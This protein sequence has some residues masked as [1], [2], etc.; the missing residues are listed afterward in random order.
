ME[1]YKKRKSFLIGTI[2]IACI[3]TCLILWNAVS[4]IAGWPEN[5]RE[6]F[7]DPNSP[8]WRFRSLLNLILLSAFH[9]L[10]CLSYIGVTLK[11]IRNKSIKLYRIAMIY[12]VLW[13]T[14]VIRY[15]I[16]WYL[17][18]L[19]HYPGFDPYIF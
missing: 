4:L 3:I 13:L 17:S 12:I 16:L 5:A 15:Y 11:A 18:D 2:V 8:H 7:I 19:D 10:L 14:W 6:Y 9:F 1:N